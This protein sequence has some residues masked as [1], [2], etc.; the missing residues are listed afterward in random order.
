[1]RLQD[2]TLQ[3]GWWERSHRRIGDNE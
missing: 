2:A 3:L 1:M